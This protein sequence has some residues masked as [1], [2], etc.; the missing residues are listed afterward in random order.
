MDFKEKINNFISFSKSVNDNNS[1]KSE[2]LK[3]VKEFHPDTNKELKKETANEYMI[4]INYTY[5]QLIHN[6]NNFQLVQEDEYERNK[7]NGKYCFTNEFGI[8]EFISD[9]ILYIYK[10]GRLE[11]GKAYMIMHNNPSYYGNKEKT[12][13]EIIGHLYRAYKYF[14][15]VIKMDKTGNWGKGA[16]RNLYYAFKMNEHI[17]RGLKIN[18]EKGI[19]KI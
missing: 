4:I 19:V 6:K 17:T 8:K 16:M 1:I 2:Y 15:D 10:L 5:E 9:K 11:Y 7:V 3:L 14:K 13:Y 18:N 12:G